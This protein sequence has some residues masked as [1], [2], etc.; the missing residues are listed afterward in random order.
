MIRDPCLADR[1][2]GARL[3]ISLGTP[4]EHEA[5]HYDDRQTA[6]DEEQHA[7]ILADRRESSKSENASA[8]GVRDKPA[9][10]SATAVWLLSK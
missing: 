7:R 5:T 1:A 3:S 4:A 9:S 8:N 6:K 2:E 10:G